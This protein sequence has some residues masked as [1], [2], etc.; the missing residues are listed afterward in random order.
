MPATSRS[1]VA[2]APAHLSGLAGSPSKS[3]AV[4]PVWVRITWPRW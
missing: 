3:S 2:R 4:Q 1:G